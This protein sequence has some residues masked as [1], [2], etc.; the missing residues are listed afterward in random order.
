[1]ILRELCL[2][3]KTKKK[4][5]QNT[6]RSNSFKFDAGSKNDRNLWNQT[7]DQVISVF[8]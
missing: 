6:F 2:I 7:F 3:K 8:S 4:Y 5:F 1:M